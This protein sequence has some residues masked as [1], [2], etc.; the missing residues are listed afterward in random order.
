MK[1]VTSFGLLLA[2]VLALAVPSAAFATHT[3]AIQA[4]SASLGPGGSVVVSGTIDCVE[5]YS[6]LVSNTV[7]QRSGLSYN[8]AFDGIFGRQGPCQ[9][10]GPQSFTSGEMFGQAPFHPGPA[11]ISSS[12]TVCD[13]FGWFSDCSS[14]T[15]TREVKINA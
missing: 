7:R 6:Y 14:A 8:T 4:T 12:V 11:V 9:T 3:A 13:T 15:D 1:R 10:T 5:G 2:S